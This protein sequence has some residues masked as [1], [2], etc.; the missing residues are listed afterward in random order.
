MKNRSRSVSLIVGFLFLALAL[1]S[2]FQVKFV[3]S[4]DEETPDFGGQKAPFTP[5]PEEERDAPPPPAN[6]TTVNEL[7]KSLFVKDNDSD[8][9]PLSI[10]NKTELLEVLPANATKAIEFVDKSLKNS[11]GQGLL[12]P[13]V[14][15]NLNE[16]SQ[17]VNASLLGQSQNGSILDILN[18]ENLTDKVLPIISP[19][20]KS[21]TS[22]D[23]E[24]VEEPQP[25]KVSENATSGGEQGTNETTIAPEQTEANTTGIKENASEKETLLQQNLQDGGAKPLINKSTEL[26]PPIKDLGKQEVNNTQIENKEL[27]PTN[28]TVNDTQTG[29]LPPT[30]LT[31]ASNTSD[32]SEENPPASLT[33]KGE[34]QDEES[35]P[36][37]SNRD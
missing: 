24:E 26:L 10:T 5:L 30:N 27:P 3:F 17:S 11:T 20:N 15:K 37:T 34:N 28:L 6:A 16:S 21:A 9:E 29:E 12:P 2:G 4:Q 18:K 22:S 23:L 36:D 7:P 19:T 33:D 31:T 1:A 13:E 8:T 14:M 25:T 35:P 32:E